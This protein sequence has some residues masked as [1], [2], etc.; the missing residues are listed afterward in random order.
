MRRKEKLAVVGS[1]FMGHDN[2][3]LQGYVLLV[4]IGLILKIVHVCNHMI[5]TISEAR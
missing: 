3:G 1:D 4:K 2:K 5:Y